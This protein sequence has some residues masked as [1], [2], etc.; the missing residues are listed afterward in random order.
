[1]K[2]IDCRGLSCPQPV[3]RTKKALDERKNEPIK[4]LLDNH[5][6]LQNVKR[7][8]SSQGCDVVI[9]EGDGVFELVIKPGAEVDMKASISDSYVV[10]ITSQTLGEGDDK[11]GSI[12]MKSF[13]NTLWD[14]DNPPVKILFLNSAVKLTC[15]GSDALDTLKLLSESGIDLVSCGTCLAFY[16]ITEKLEVGH[17]G[18]MYEVV[19]SLLGSTKVIKI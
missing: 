11:L 7:F 15:E 18:N 2:Q 6:S 19:E 9:T 5:G 17:A 13:L 1:M 14:N 10:L 16:E 4:V 12:L 8:A 3:I